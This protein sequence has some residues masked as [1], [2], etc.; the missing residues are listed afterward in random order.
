[1][2]T[3]TQLPKDDQPD[4]R[5]DLGSEALDTNEGQHDNL[6]V[7]PER[8]EAEADDLERAYNAP[9]A[10]E[11]G[12]SANPDGASA[13]TPEQLADAE[14]KGGIPE[15][16]KHNRDIPES[17]RR[18]G[19]V[20]DEEGPGK[21]VFKPDGKPVKAKS[22][23]RKRL[24]I[25]AGS[26]GGLVAVI[27]VVVILALLSGLKL[28]NLAAH[29]A[30][31]NFARIARTDSQSA[32][33]LTSERFA[34]D[35]ADESVLTNLKGN[36]S[37]FFA[38]FDKFRP[39][40]VIDNLKTDGNLQFVYNE[41]PRGGILGDLGWT[42]LQ[43]DSVRVNGSDIAI[44]DHQFGRFFS[45][46]SND[47][48]FSAE[49]NS[50]IANAYPDAGIV[51]R[52]QV[53]QN[54]REEIGLDSLVWWKNA[55]AAWKGKSQ[56]DA[57]KLEQQTDYE[58]V[59][60]P[61][62]SDPLSPDG[63]DRANQSS[64]TVDKAVKDGTAPE[65]NLANIQAQGAGSA[66]ADEI[67]PSAEAA[68]E[69][70]FQQSAG[71][72]IKGLIKSQALV[73][74]I[75]IPV[76]IIYDGS[77]VSSPNTI[78]AKN[79][80][81]QKEY[82]GLEIS[83]DQQKFGQTVGEAVGAANDKYG[84]ISNSV[85]ELRAQGK[86]P[87]TTQGLF[88]PGLPQTGATGQ[89]N[90]ANT[91]LGNGYIANFVHSTASSVCPK[92][93]DFKVIVAQVV[94]GKIIE[95]LGDIFS[96]GGATAAETGAVDAANV[97]ADEAANEVGNVVANNVADEVAQQAGKTVTDQALQTLRQKAWGVT[98]KFG[99]DLALYGG[100]SLLARLT[101]I[102]HMNQT[103]NGL[104]TNT[105]AA[106]EADMG[107]NL[108]A[109]RQLQVGTM[110]APMT[111]QDTSSSEKADTAYLNNQHSKQSVGQRYF[112][113]RNPDS[114]ISKVGF[115]T[116]GQLQTIRFS[117]PTI[118]TGFIKQVGSLLSGRTISNIF[119]FARPAYAAAGTQSHD[120]GI[121]QWGWTE[122]ELG[123][124]RSND[125]YNPVNNATTIGRD[126]VTYKAISDK[127]GKCFTATMGT[128]LA[129]QDI[130]RNDDG[131]VAPDK[132]LC[133]P[134]NLGVN[135]TDPNGPCGSGGCG[136]KVFRWRINGL[137][138][139]ELNNL[140]GVQEPSASPEATPTVPPQ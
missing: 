17:A 62:V 65:E 127:Y 53:A 63:S 18:H 5:P 82:Y 70:S 87:D 130:Q 21:F 104:S 116:L 72:T 76:C 77:V 94:F 100:L 102:D 131:S 123:I 10:G 46:T 54:I 96:F 23:N 43:L 114:M 34:V 29:V 27:A 7:H 134:N 9:A 41:V 132:G 124:I 13:A 42:K 122:N 39:A 103:Y 88:G 91:L 60:G 92:I 26:G 107:G 80:A 50:S 81:L 133:S 135:N 119:N 69:K 48:N 47:I 52:S 79:A 137:N 78:D 59:H 44:P 30:E 89:Y 121:V 19:G 24:L 51:V 20:L 106:N 55:A 110:A 115:A 66:A 97:A 35:A 3:K 57:V 28:Q 129:D 112:A 84:N 16:I 37:D 61:P 140:L 56:V 49:L 22:K 2:D 12:E 6:G 4:I 109:Q 90:I 15:D 67:V 38:R 11:E 68:L 85:P 99:K 117:I 126:P 113:I 71:D 40:K 31:Y 33:D 136:D 36:A 86:I 101:V 1:M 118:L 73:T 8:R 128:L 125:S 14:E 111:A 98:Q 139:N 105:S 93:L 25:I 108:N 45:N 74:Q 75:A 95:G 138:N 58:L 120:Y 32:S 83:A 64:D